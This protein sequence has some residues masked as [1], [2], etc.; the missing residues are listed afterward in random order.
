MHVDLARIESRHRSLLLELAANQEPA[1]ELSLPEFEE[2]FEDKY[3]E[4]TDPY[5][6]FEALLD[7]QRYRDNPDWLRI[8]VDSAT[9]RRRRVLHIA[10]DRIADALIAYFENH[11]RLIFPE[12]TVIVAESLNR[13]GEFLEAEVLRKRADTFWNFAVYDENGELASSALRFD[14]EGNS[15]P[16]EAGFRV[17]HSCSVCHRIDRLDLSGDPEAPVR[18]PIR[19][20]FH[21]LPARV[22]QIHLSQEHYDHMAF[23][24]LTEATA[25]VKDGVFGVYGSLLLSELKGRARLEALSENDRARYLRLQPHYPEL[26]TPLERTESFVNSIGM[27]FMRI[28]APPPGTMIGSPERDPDYQSDERRHAVSFEHDFFLQSKVVTNAQFRMFRPSH[29]SADYRGVE[30]NGADHPVVNVNLADARGF[31][32]WLNQL[33]SEKRTGRTYRLPAEQEWEYA[34]RGGDDRRFP[35]GD[36][37]PPPEGAG[38]LGDAAS[39]RHFGWEALAEYRDPFIGTSPVGR[40]F[41]SPFFLYDMAGNVYEWTSSEYERYPGAG[42]GKEKYGAGLIT[43]R[44]SSWADE[45]PK[46]FRCAFRQPRPPGLK[47]PFLGFRVAAELKESTDDSVSDKH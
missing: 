47:I 22:P 3:Y 2:Y 8:P 27:K 20:F 29:R 13:E 44:G 18:A 38:N 41:S 28:P 34:A 11:N 19:G 26:L 7:E 42:G 30:L 40:F 1:G 6:D 39:G 10:K 32:E 35:W 16:D 46:V 9:F 45:L 37:W 14:K 25:K 21:R 33:P 24:E 17:P 31:I 4:L 23:T 15:L 5:L 36:A 12:G 43:V